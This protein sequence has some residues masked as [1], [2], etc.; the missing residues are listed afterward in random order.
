MTVPGNPTP[1]D[2]T[3]DGAVALVHVDATVAMAFI[4]FTA[5]GRAAG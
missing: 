2:A 4:G 1:L 5:F 3:S